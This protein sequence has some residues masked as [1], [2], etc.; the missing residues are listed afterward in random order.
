MNA[1]KLLED[2]AAISE[3]YAFWEKKTAANFNIISILNAADDEVRICRILHAL[4][5]PDG[6]HGQGALY[7]KLFVENV[8]AIDN[9]HEADYNS[10][11]VFREYVLANGHRIDL[12]IQTQRYFI[13]IE[14]KIYAGDQDKQCY[15]YY[16]YA[17]MGEITS[18]EN[19]HCL[20]FA[21]DI[22][23]WLRE[24]RIQEETLEVEI[25]RSTFQQIIESVEALTDQ[26][27]GGKDLELT[28][29]LFASKENMENA[30][31]IQK[32]YKQ[33]Q[34]MLLRKFF[35]RLEEK[36]NLP[37]LED[38]AL[39][40]ET[41]NGRLLSTFYEKSASTYP[42]INYFCKSLRDGID[43]WFRIEIEAYPY[44]G[45]CTPKNRQEAG[46]QLTETER[47]SLFGEAA[48]NDGW[49]VMWEYPP[50]GERNSS[51][52]FKTSDQNYFSLYDEERFV[53]FID[54]SYSRMKEITD[55]YSGLTGFQI[56]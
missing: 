32:N 23:P 21:T 39:D 3:K 53:G 36:I 37:R 12:V 7:L 2:A 49:W 48:K 47:C 41:G 46:K 34:I 51:I 28:E 33:A 20:S 30:W 55:K 18:Y 56:P 52:N 4:L 26:P 17:K 50:F 16:Q 45:F 19:V 1:T 22:L 54:E 13:P 42:G 29:V 24:C 11:R 31:T 5:N 14:V 9:F 43:L 10:A 35:S 15:D 27:K 6:T 44:F 38:S 40:Y 25:L 8:L